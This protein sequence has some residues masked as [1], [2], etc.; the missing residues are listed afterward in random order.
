M[1]RKILVPAIAAAG[2]AVAVS[3]Y[4]KKQLDTKE[5]HEEEDDNE[6]NFINILDDEDE[7]EEDE[8]MEVSQFSAND[9]MSN[10]PEEV[11]QISKIYSHLHPMFIEDLFEKNTMFNELYPED[12]LVTMY[13]TACFKDEKSSEVFAQIM[14]E[15]GYQYAIDG[16]DVTVSRKMFVEN[17]AILSDIYNVANQVNFLEGDYLGYQ[18]EK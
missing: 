11:Q 3:A 4:L 8:E 16:L 18:I 1:L 2:V 10:Y 15:D 12:T 9:D 7:F 13:H 17:G 6:V 5:E 14:E